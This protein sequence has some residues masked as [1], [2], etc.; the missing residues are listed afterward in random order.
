MKC[1][2]LLN[3][4]NDYID[5]EIDPAVCKEFEKHMADCNPC[6]IVIDTIKKTITIYK[7][8]KP[9]ELPIEFRQKLH[10]LL[11]EKWKSNFNTKPQ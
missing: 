11:Q 4:L 9:Y 8:G 10:S 5:G 6:Q 2:D 1:R 7:E 3:V